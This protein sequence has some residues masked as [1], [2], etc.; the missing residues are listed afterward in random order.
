MLAPHP[1]LICYQTGCGPPRLPQ[2]LLSSSGP[3]APMQGHPLLLPLPG[4]KSSVSSFCLQ[5][6]MFSSQKESARRPILSPSSQSRCGG[7]AGVH[8]CSLP[9]RSHCSF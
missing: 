1:L 7:D 8:P 4:S 9:L 3:P 2:G 5:T 6:S